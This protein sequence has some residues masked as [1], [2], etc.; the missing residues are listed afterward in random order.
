[1]AVWSDGFW[2]SADGLRLH[3]RDYA[4]RED[5]PPILCLPGLTRNARDFE[6][7]A[8]RLAGEWRLI[9]VDLRGRAGSAQADDAAS[10]SPP[11][12]VADVERLIAALGLERFVPFGTSLGGLIA[13]LLAWR[14]P[15]RIAAVLLNDVGPELNPAG[16]ERIRSYIGRQQRW[17]DWD[18]AA[19][20]LSEAHGEVYPDW[21]AER[22]PV[23]ARRLCREQPDGS[24]GL[25]YDMRIAEPILAAPA[26]A[27]AFDLWP[28]LQALRGVPSLLVRGGLSDLLSEEVAQRMAEAIGTLQVATVPRVGHA[29]TLEEPEAAAAIDRLLA[30]IAA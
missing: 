28:A 1:M 3:Y 15:G 26:D 8:D 20:W 22:W 29:P 16:L 27:P 17:S 14:D 13:M 9:A 21:S 11:V 2:D 19:G 10:Y 4:G 23:Q 12:Y 18:E 24:I 6:G 7:V 25:D 5:R 30:Q